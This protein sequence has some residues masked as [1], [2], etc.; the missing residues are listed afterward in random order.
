MHEGYSP[1][2]AAVMLARAHRFL[3]E[4]YLRQALVEGVS[5]LEIALEE[6]MRERIGSA[7]I[8][9]KSLSSFW[10]LP[11]RT[12]IVS[13]AGTLGTKYLQGIE[14][15][16]KAIDNRNK[17]VHEGWTPPDTA[18]VELRALL[19]SVARLLPGPSFRFP[20]SRAGNRLRPPESSPS[21][22]S[23]MS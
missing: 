17:V 13:I 8:L 19:N 16:L 15:T 9:K 23:S 20:S 18:N 1:S 12:R 14:P 5:C 11:L 3:D 22:E 2:L 7:S 21:A 6:F 4:G 10:D